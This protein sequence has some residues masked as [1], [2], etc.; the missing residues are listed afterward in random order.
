[1]TLRIVIAVLVIAGIGG[2]ALFESRNLIRGPI[3][4]IEEPTNGKLFQTS[5]ARVKG[6]AQNIVK[7]S[8]NDREISVDE[9][10]FFN[11]KY[12]LSK[13]SNV[14][15]ISAEDRFGRQD[16]TLVEIYYTEPNETLVQ[17]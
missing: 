3:V 4:T 14:V 8:M 6:H 7:I 9:H 2:Y 1:M 13:G 16:D 10:G 5:V 12:V 15:K 11:E 17:R